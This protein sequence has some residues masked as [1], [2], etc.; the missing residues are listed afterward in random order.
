[1]KNKFFSIVMAGFVSIGL[2]GCGGDKTVKDAENATTSSVD[3][4]NV[5]ANVSK[6]VMLQEFD[7]HDA[8]RMARTYH[9]EIDPDGK[10]GKFL[11]TDLASMKT[12]LETFES[13]DQNYVRIYFGI[14]EDDLCTDLTGKGRKYLTVFFEGAKLKQGMAPCNPKECKECFLEEDEKVV[15]VKPWDVAQPCP[16]PKCQGFSRYYDLASLVDSKSPMKP[17]EKDLAEK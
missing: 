17:R 16:P 4:G 12:M 5:S 6:N 13:R 9:S 15:S 14:G 2:L 8:I 1:M 10:Y 7:Y 11:W 3:S